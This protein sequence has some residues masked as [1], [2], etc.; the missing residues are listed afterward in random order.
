VHEFGKNIAAA[1]SKSSLY[2]I[3]YTECSGLE[4][5]YVAIRTHNPV[6]IIYN[7]YPSTMPWIQKKVF[8]RLYRPLNGGIHIPQIGIM[9]EVTQEKA[10]KADNYLFDYHIAPDPTLLLKNPIVFKT[11]RLVPEYHN[12]YPLS[13]IPTIGSF[14]FATPNKGFE[15]IVGAVN[16]EFDE[17]VIR[18]NIPSADFGDK[19]GSRAR[20]LVEKCRGLITKT[21]IKLVVSNDFLSQDGILNF[22]AQ[23]TVN[24]FLY[25][26]K[27]GRGISSAADYALAVER[28]V[29]VSDSSMFRNLQAIEPSIVYGRSSI[30]EIIRQGIASLQPFKQR[31]NEENIIWEYERILNRILN[32]NSATRSSLG[33]TGKAKLFLKQVT[34]R[35]EKSFTWLRN[36]DVATEDDLSFVSNRSYEPVQIPENTSLNRILDNA[37]RALYAP[38]IKTITSLVP[39]TVAEKI[40]EANVQQAFVFDTVIRFGKNYSDPKMLCVGSYEDTA[41]MSL[42]RMGYKIEEIDPVLNYYLQ[43]YV[44]RPGTIKHSYDIIFSTSVIEHDPDDGSFIACISDLLSPGGVAILTCDYNNQWK[45]GDL[46]PTVDERLYTKHDLKERLL[47]LM[48]DCELVD[49]PQWECPDPDFL[50]LNKYRYTFA[51]IV[52]RKSNQ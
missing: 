45:P 27:A 37:A 9:H 51:T 49:D 2:K 30:K 25:Q 18:F 21:G 4:E 46:K 38:A 5:M 10:D 33:F 44:N 13:D 41:A 47:P 23:N 16:E 31:W 42:S 20:Q 22:L 48:K 36:T 1:I 40:A 52:V 7:Y 34:G 29:T 17:A 43:E 32:N 39:L 8:H 28:P 15:Q 12:T 11:G 6:A 24:I 19:D 26:D 50:Y 14:G 35:S 3:V